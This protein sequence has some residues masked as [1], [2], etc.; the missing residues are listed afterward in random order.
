[1]TWISPQDRTEVEAIYSSI[2]QRFKEAGI[3]TAVIGGNIY[4]M[5]DATNVFC[6]PSG[7]SGYYLVDETIPFY[8][9]VLH[10]LVPYSSEVINQTGDET[11]SILQAVEYGAGFAYRWMY[12]ENK[13]LQT[14][15]FEEAYSLNYA[16]GINDAIKAY[17]RY[18]SELGH[19][20]GLMI[21]GHAR[22]AEDV[23]MTRY[24]DGT[25][26][27]VNYSGSDYV[28]EGVTIPARDYTVVKGGRV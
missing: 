12:A 15:Y 23:A 8:Q 7:S 22:L 27:Y 14:V 3:D 10:G 4:A 2:M 28:H 6:L 19:T 25:V 1:M 17:N 18:N 16:S 21:V 5:A 20:A 9:I 24:E 13:S 11:R 26:V